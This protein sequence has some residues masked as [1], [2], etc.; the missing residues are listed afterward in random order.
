M[1][2]SFQLQ[3]PGLIPYAPGSE[4]RCNIFEFPWVFCLAQFFDCAEKCT[5]GKDINEFRCRAGSSCAWSTGDGSGN[6]ECPDKCNDDDQREDSM[7]ELFV[8]QCPQQ[9]SWDFPGSCAET[10]GEEG[11]ECGVLGNGYR[12]DPGFVYQYFT[13]GYSSSSVNNLELKNHTSGENVTFTNELAQDCYDSG[14]Y[15][16]DRSY[17]YSV[18]KCFVCMK[19]IP[20]NITSNITDDYYILN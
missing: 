5:S 8:S 19:Q 3:V 20:F 18:K 6:C 14:S 10:V 1:A 17:S 16:G 13:N 9:D 11:W 4:C 2:M 12:V 15:N 7:R